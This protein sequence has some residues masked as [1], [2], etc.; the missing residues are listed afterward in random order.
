MEDVIIKVQIAKGKFI[1][2]DDET[3]EGLEDICDGLELDLIQVKANIG[4]AKAE[5]VLT[6]EYADPMWFRKA[7]TAKSLIARNRSILQRAIKR[8]K[9]Q[10]IETERKTFER[11]F[12]DAAKVLLSKEA[13][14][15]LVRLARESE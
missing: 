7:S 12:V 5:L 11:R 4:D 14:Q 8:K 3:I 2:T 9:K 1:K 15:E 13:F 6:G 10:P